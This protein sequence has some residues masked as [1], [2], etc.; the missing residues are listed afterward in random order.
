MTDNFEQK[1]KRFSSIVQE[2]E[3]ADVSI[4]NSM[5]LYEEAIKIHKEA[6]EYLRTMELKLADVNESVDSK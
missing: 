5:S 2:L 3:K 6:Q 4:E 1:M